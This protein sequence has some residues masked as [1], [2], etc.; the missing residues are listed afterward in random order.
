MQILEIN[1]LHKGTHYLLDQI[2]Y[3][4]LVLEVKS[5]VFG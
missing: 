1:K 2:F 3:K 4:S 5:E